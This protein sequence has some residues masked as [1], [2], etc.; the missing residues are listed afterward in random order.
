MDKVDKLYQYYD[1][2]ADPKCNTAEHESKYLEIVNA[3]KGAASEKMLACQFIP[4]FLKEFPHMAESALDAVLDLVE[5]D[6]VAIRKHAVK[7]LPSFCKYSKNFVSKV[8]D[9]L[10]QML[11][12][13]DSSEVATVQASLMTILKLDVKS[14]LQGIFIQISQTEDELIRKRTIQFLC[15]KFKFLPPELA[16]KEIEEFVLEACKKA[17]PTIS[18]EDFLT[19][20]PLLSNLKI[21]KTIPV[22]QILVQL[23]AEQAEIDEEFQA[24]P[25][26]VAG[27][28][29]CV[30]HALPYF[31][32]FVNS[33]QFVNHICIVVLPKLK[34][35]SEFENGEEMSL[36]IIKVLAEI[37]PFVSEDEHLKACIE[38][39]YKILLEYIPLPPAA[40]IE[41]G[42]STDE[43]NLQF[44]HIECFL[45]IFTQLLKFYPEFLT[46]AENSQLFKDLKAR[47]QFLARGVQSG[48]KTFRESLITNKTK[49]AKPE[50]TKLKAI[51]LRTMNNINTLIKDLFRSP[52][53]FKTTVTL[54]WKPVTAATTK[55]TSEK[56]EIEAPASQ[57]KKPRR[58]TKAGRE[59]YSPPGGKY[60]TNVNSY[61]RTRGSNYYPRGR[62]R[63]YY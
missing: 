18:G 37:S 2:L 26:N 48:I 27:F 44:T 20:L 21:A 52:P 45:F 7:H 22:Q 51:A 39:I 5:D 58:D 28:L 49:E 15:T 30:R 46:S 36:D 12:T 47:L 33:V 60:S 31:S 8:A 10:A 54:S 62:G 16:T 38:I 63:R 23:I 53:T 1:I 41:N 35:I 6:D 32:P 13:E 50:E 42:S 55:L 24:S 56:R 25:D 3:T 14:T 4:R 59:L 11:Q 57:D 29:Q 19:L 17:F 9:I 40:D 34:E 61:P 43:P